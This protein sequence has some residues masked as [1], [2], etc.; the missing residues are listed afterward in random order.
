MKKNMTIS[1]RLSGLIVLF[2]IGLGI[3]LLTGSIELW[4]VKG[5]INEI[6][7]KRIPSITMAQDLNKFASEYRIKQYGLLAAADD[8]KMKQYENELEEILE[9][10]EVKSKEYQLYL[11]TDKEWELFQKA[12]ASWEAYAAHSTE[13]IKMLEQGSKALAEERMTN[14]WKTEYDSFNV[15]VEQMIAYDIKANAEMQNSLNTSIIVMI[16]I[17]AFV[18]AAAVFLCAKLAQSIKKSILQPLHMI[19]DSVKKI[20]DG[21]LSIKIDYS[22]SDELG[23]IAGII[24]EFIVN[25]NSIIQDENRILEEMSDGNFAVTSSMI[26]KYKGDFR[27]ILESMRGIKYRLGAV[28]ENI[29]DAAVQVNTASEQMAGAAETLAEGAAEQAGSVQEILAM[30]NN[31][32]EMAAGSAKRAKEASQYAEDVKKQAAMGNG[33]MSNMVSEMEVISDTSKEIA[34][35]IAAIEEIA[36]QTNLLA[37]NASIEA[38]RAGEAGRGF[39]V[40]A[41]E[42]GKLANQSS[43]AATNTRELIQKSIAQVETGNNIAKQ[44][45]E[46]F[47]SMDSGIKM[48]AG[49]NEEME[50]ACQK[51]VHSI[52]EITSGVEVIT[53]VVESNSAAAQESSATS[54][55][56]AAHAANL[57]EMLGEFS[58]SK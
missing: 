25:L 40:V 50:D 15:A 24:N 45:L 18:A 4:S 53:N 48:V 16:L 38:A 11:E 3:I 2:S 49:L 5:S 58:F 33:H 37:L 14:E 32:E 44:T 34:T 8:D 21:E 7:Q 17:K 10:I 20:Q 56:L 42:I 19:N 26:E 29:K 36:A 43:E 46:A 28:L 35:I 39:A 13:I 51:Q 55:E 47:H 57:Q 31:V 52:R 6:A 30:M 54:E 23:E 22:K 41:G 9:Q 27:P 12:E 1:M